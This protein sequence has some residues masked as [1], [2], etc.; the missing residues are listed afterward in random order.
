M[1]ILFLDDNKLRWD[2]LQPVIRSYPGTET[3]W[4]QTV[5]ECIKELEK[6]IYDVVMLDHDLGGEIMVKSGKGTGY[7]VA[8]WIANNMKDCMPGRIYIH[9]QNPEGSKNMKLVLPDAVVIPF[10]ML[11]MQLSKY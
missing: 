3:T 1:K 11:M 9:T 7:E 6:K 2:F 4:V 8:E 5:E 10:P